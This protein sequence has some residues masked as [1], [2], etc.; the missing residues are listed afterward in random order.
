MDIRCELSP[1]VGVTEEVAYDCE[2]GAGDLQ[3]DVPPRA[4]NLC[5]GN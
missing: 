5:E 2:D 4:D 3:R 1:A